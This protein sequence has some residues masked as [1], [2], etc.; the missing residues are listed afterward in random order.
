MRSNLCPT[1]YIS[2]QKLCTQTRTHWTATETVTIKKNGPHDLRLTQSWFPKGQSGQVK[3]RLWWCHRKEEQGQLEKGQPDD[4]A[5]HTHSYS[6]THSH[7]SLTVNHMSIFSWSTSRFES[8]TFSVCRH[9]QSFTTRQEKEERDVH[10]TSST[11][12]GS[13]VLIACSC[14]H[15]E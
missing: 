7:F 11:L 3:R 13:V 8:Q 5:T 9:L 6:R 1:S 4:R 12:S 14:W 2:H 15:C 10:R